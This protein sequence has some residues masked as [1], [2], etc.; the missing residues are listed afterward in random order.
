LGWEIQ[1]TPKTKSFFGHFL[2]GVWLFQYK[3]KKVYFR[4]NLRKEG[5]QGLRYALLRAWFDFLIQIFVGVKQD[6]EY[7]ETKEYKEKVK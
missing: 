5:F 7:W 6:I 3:F 4:Q 1:R 2:R